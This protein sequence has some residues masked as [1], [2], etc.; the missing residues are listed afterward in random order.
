MIRK[1]FAALLILAGCLTAGITFLPIEIQESNLLIQTSVNSVLNNQ[2]V[3]LRIPKFLPEGEQVLFEMNLTAPL[4]HA[5]GVIPPKQLEA[6]LDLPGVDLFPSENLRVP[7]IA[8]Q[9]I[10]FRWL[11]SAQTQPLTSGTLWLVEIGVDA[12]GEET[13]QPLLARPFELDLQQV[14][15]L[16]FERARWL[17]G[18]LIASGLLAAFFRLKRK[19]KTKKSGL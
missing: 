7:Y 19:Q 4:N 3:G 5:D 13:R 9:H 15:G 12:A 16:S 10:S 1:L 18:G 6:R 11:V 2:P 8:G 14:L 17:G